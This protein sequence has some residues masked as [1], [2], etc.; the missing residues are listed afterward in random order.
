M[1]TL[2]ERGPASRR[3]RKNLERNRP[4]LRDAYYYALVSLRRTIDEFFGPSETRIA[5][6]NSLEFFIKL[7]TIYN[8][9][10]LLFVYLV[11]GVSP[12]VINL[13]ANSLSR[14][15][16]ATLMIC[17]VLGL[18]LAFVT[19]INPNFKSSILSI[20]TSIFMGLT[21]F[22]L[23][24]GYGMILGFDILANSISYWFYAIFFAAFVGQFL[25]ALNKSGFVAVVTLMSIL[26][27]LFF[28]LIC[29][30]LMAMA[31][32]IDEKDFRGPD[33]FFKINIW[34]FSALA[35]IALLLTYLFPFAM[36]TVAEQF[37]NAMLLRYG[38]QRFYIC[39]LVTAIFI[40]LGSCL[41][42]PSTQ[43]LVLF[44]LPTLAMPIISILLDWSAFQMADKILSLAVKAEG[45]HAA[46]SAAA[47]LAIAG[48]SSSVFILLFFWTANIAA[49]HQSI[50]DNFKFVDPKLSVELLK[51][52]PADPRLWWLYAL[53][54]FNSLPLLVNLTAAAFGL[55]SWKTPEWASKR[56]SAYIKT[57]FK[58]DYPRLSETS[59][60]LTLRMVLS[61]T[62]SAGIFL[63]SGWLLARVL[64]DA[65]SVIFKILEFSIGSAH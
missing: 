53:M 18:A 9:G 23:V 51:E 2:C 54:A 11:S 63:V 16:R 8:F 21:P 35:P 17:S 37:E 55:L 4:R 27:A 64:P 36:R 56:Y 31:L 10:T 42:L 29:L 61:A 46:L 22:I 26:F 41:A 62:L 45:K 24:Q 30:G 15:E 47:N 5:R 52:S 7:S 13:F 40:Y 48:I 19:Q 49:V 39:F 33:S 6:I 43:V 44:L 50:T 12:T 32:G 58:G 34:V 60:F 65:A 3:I 25:T 14:T 20:A 28:Q 59:L 57:G 38:K 1:N